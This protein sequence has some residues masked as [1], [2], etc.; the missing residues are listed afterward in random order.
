MTREL[1]PAETPALPTVHRPTPIYGMF[2]DIQGARAM[3]ADELKIDIHTATQD[4][5]NEAAIN[6]ISRNFVCK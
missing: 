3:V 6:A 2:T 4:L 1:S 5:D